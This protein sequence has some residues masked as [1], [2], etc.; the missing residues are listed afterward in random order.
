MRWMSRTGMRHDRM[1]HICSGMEAAPDRSHD[2][3]ASANSFLIR[4]VLV[5]FHILVCV[6]EHA[7]VGRTDS[8]D[9]V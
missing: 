9:E 4:L 7:N 2:L 6:L 1:L 5:P 3:D 8:V